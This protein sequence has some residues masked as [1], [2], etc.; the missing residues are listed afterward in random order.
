MPRIR[1]NRVL[2]EDPQED[3]RD[4]DEIFFSFQNGGERT[5]PG[6]RPRTQTIESMNGGD[7]KYITDIRNDGFVT[8]FFFDTSVT[9]RLWEDDFGS[10]PDDLLGGFYFNAR[11][12]QPSPD[13]DGG[14]DAVFLVNNVRYVVNYD[15][16]L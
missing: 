5:P 12:V 6:G 2:C 11:Q 14:I 3:N 16:F 15:I 10:N 7:E 13:E 8:E 9:V 4:G 1:L